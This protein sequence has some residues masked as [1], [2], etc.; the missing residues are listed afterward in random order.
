M[1][2]DAGA[3]RVRGTVVYRDA[4]ANGYAPRRRGTEAE[5]PAD[6]VED[7]VGRADSKIRFHDGDSFRTAF[8][9]WF[10]P[11]VAPKTEE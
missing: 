2:S 9:P 10:E 7:A 8:Y 1:Y 11:G 6:C 3:R 4:A 5:G